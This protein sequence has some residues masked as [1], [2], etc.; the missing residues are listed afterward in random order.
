MRITKIILEN[1]QAHKYTEL[2]VNVPITLI[3]GSSDSGKSSVI[4]IL[5]WIFFN[6]APKGKFMLD[7]KVI[8]RGT[9]IYDTGDTL[10][11]ERGPN[12]NQY[13]LNDKVFK[14]LRTDVPPEIWKFHQVSL[15]N[16]QWQ[17]PHYFLLD[18][19]P[20]TVAKRLNEVVDLEIMSE[21]Q[22]IANARV[23][24][25]DQAVTLLKTDIK[26]T[27][28]KVQ[29]LDWLSDAESFLTRGKQLD[30]Q[31]EDKLRV[32]ETVSNVIARIKTQED[33]LNSF[34]DLSGLPIIKEG[35]LKIE[36]FNQEMIVQEQLISICQKILAWQEQIAR[37]PDD[38]DI[39]K[40]RLLH[41]NSESLLDSR[42]NLATVLIQIESLQENLL[43]F[44]KAEE[45]V[46]LESYI[47]GRTDIIVS[48]STLRQ[49]ITNV[50]Q[51]KKRLTLA[52]K[53][54]SRAQTAY[55]DFMEKLGIC[56]FCGNTFKK[57]FIT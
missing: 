54:T 9:L 51:Q 31:R 49:A 53:E 3:T 15:D 35:L 22:K 27:K 50:E 48:R 11:R 7:E 57:G 56:P 38:A 47:S 10:I 33:R 17:H 18:E 5:R 46:D 44:P 16:C 4:R 20:G 34:E 52:E 55:L 8:T 29:A 28:D 19:T 45:G 26:E 36:K 6:R 1:F 14:A 21:S 2:D 39:Q 32:Q 24:S 40:I 13:R 30:S 43:K 41:T 23:K 37:L 25:V 42:D 12:L